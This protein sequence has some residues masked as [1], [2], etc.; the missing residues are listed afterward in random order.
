MNGGPWPCTIR[1]PSSDPT[2]EKRSTQTL[3]TFHHNPLHMGN[4]QV[5]L[6]DDMDEELER[7]AKSIHGSRSDALRQA[8]G[9]GLES[10]RRRRAMEQYEQGRWS[11][12][13]AA[14][15]ARTSVHEMARLASARG[16]AI[17]RQDAAE[18]ER[19]AAAAQEALR[20]G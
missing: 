7:L 3:N 10:L 2:A 1:M 6:P 13:R 4:V 11:L 20:A 16:L 14:E 17:M 12:S 5:R 18:A 15:E 19:D 9:A 8:L